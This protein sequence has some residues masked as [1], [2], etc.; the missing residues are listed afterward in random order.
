MHGWVS[1]VGD[2]LVTGLFLKKNVWS[3]KQ[4][5]KFETQFGPAAV[6]KV[7]TRDSSTS[8]QIPILK[9]K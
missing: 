9:M 4:C 6:H 7:T 8:P 2:G 5:L 1:I 3:K